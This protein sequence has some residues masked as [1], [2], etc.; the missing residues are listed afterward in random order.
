MIPIFRFTILLEDSEESVRDKSIST[1]N[2]GINIG[3]SKVGIE[4][5]ENN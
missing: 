2:R 4:I 3:I 1:N 5:D